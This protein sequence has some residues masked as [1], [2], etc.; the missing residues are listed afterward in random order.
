MGCC[1]YFLSFLIINSICPRAE[2]VAT[3]KP[4]VVGA[5]VVMAEPGKAGGGGNS[6]NCRARNGSGS[7]G[8]CSRFVLILK[9][10]LRNAL[11]LEVPLTDLV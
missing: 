5:K 8:D 10:N 1:I 2:V 4:G 7:S 9:I 11:Y 3:E 6:G